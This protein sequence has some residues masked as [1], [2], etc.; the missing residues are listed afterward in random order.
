[1]IMDIDQGLPLMSALPR[2]SAQDTSIANG[3]PNNHKKNNAQ[4]QSTKEQI[5]QQNGGG[6]SYIPCT[7]TVQP[8]NMHKLKKNKQRDTAH[9]N[10]SK[11]TV[12]EEAHP[13]PIAATRYGETYPAWDEAPPRVQTTETTTR[14]AT[15]IEDNA[16]F[17]DDAT[18]ATANNANLAVHIFFAMTR[19][20]GE[21]PCNHKRKKEPQETTQPIYRTITPHLLAVLLDT[22]MNTNC[23]HTI[24][25]LTTNWS[26]TNEKRGKALLILGCMR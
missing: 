21:N 10:H 24:R 8:K 16:S 20:S 7:Y 17:I 11:L 13:T 26:D 2:E 19:S 18:V 25:Q 22:Y 23:T 6:H 4:H 3:T 15:S 12:R 1:M 9:S 5:N 14:I